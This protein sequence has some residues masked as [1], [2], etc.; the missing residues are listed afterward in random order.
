MPKILN[1][2]GNKLLPATHRIDSA[3][4]VFGKRVFRRSLPASEAGSQES[5]PSTSLATKPQL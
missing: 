1:G 3:G 4:S 5:T 2:H